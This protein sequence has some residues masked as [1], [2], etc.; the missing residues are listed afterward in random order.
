MRI[1]KYI[2]LSSA[3]AGALAGGLA[4]AAAE[5]QPSSLL[6]ADAPPV[7]YDRADGLTY[8]MSRVDEKEGNFR[9]FLKAARPAVSYDNHTPEQLN[10]IE[11]SAGVQFHLKF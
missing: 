2:I 3:L 5:R 4:H 8:N 1:I 10:A 9:F 6:P 11:P 7:A